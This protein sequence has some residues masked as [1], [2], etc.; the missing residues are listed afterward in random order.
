MVTAP[1]EEMRCDVSCLMEGTSEF[2]GANKR[3]RAERAVGS[4]WETRRAK[5]LTGGLHVSMISD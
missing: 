5:L 2:N 4:A 3:V 1:R